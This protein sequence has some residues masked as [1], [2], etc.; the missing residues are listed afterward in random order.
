MRACHELIYL[1]EDYALDTDRRELRR[2]SKLVSLE[3]Q[4]FD[5]LECLVRKRARI[6]TK[7][8]L[9]ADVW[10]NRIVSDS[11][12][13]SRITA[14]RHAVAD[15]GD[16]Q[17]LIRTVPR[18][19]F[20][21]IGAVQQTEAEPK[22]NSWWEKSSGREEWVPSQLERA[23]LPLPD[24]PSIAVLPFVNLSEEAGQEYFA[25]GISEDIITALSRFRWLFVIARNSSF[26]YKSQAVDVRQIGRELG[27]R[28]VL[29]GSVRKAAN[30]V[31]ITAQLV[32]TSNGSHLWADRFDGALEDIFDLQDQVSA[33]VIGSIAPK[34]EQAEIERARRKPTESLDAYDHY[35][36]GMAKAV[37]YTREGYDEAQRHFYRAIELDPEFAAPYGM[38]A[39]Y[40][41]T[42]KVN[43]WMI[44]HG[45]EIAEGA[46][47]AKLAIELA[48]DDAV[49]LSWGGFALGFFV[50]LDD[51]IAY[52]DRALV[53]N[54]N[55]AAG[56]YMSGWLRIFAGEPEA[57][58][59]RLNRSMR[60]S[61]LDPLIFRVYAGLAYANFFANR[62]VEALVWAERAVRDRPTWLTAVRVAAACHAATGHLEAAK[63]LIARVRELDPALHVSNL[64]GVHPF[65]RPEDLAKWEA[66]IRKA[67]LPE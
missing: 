13:S 12:L 54:A 46:R 16:R 25:D 31:R 21:F 52:V 43:G 58:I 59:E 50:D 36:R 4:V 66:A 63:Q 18:K 33:S 38:A 55:L 45:Q 53:L 7:D 62:D 14:V 35:L 39:W 40:Y 47:L 10:N 57:A 1:F 11:T 29:E 51:G 41:I 20:R 15:D 44:D 2:G 19:G 22:D 49:A 34:L 48:E 17:R 3:P 37:P 64:R 28:Y 61:P 32:D 26:V 24:K 60:L 42:R 65:R 8:D 6:V 30:R 27:V 5:L 56:W 67:G 9:I 23:P